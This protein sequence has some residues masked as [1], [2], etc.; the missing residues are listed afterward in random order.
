MVRAARTWVVAVMALGL[1]GCDPGVRVLAQNASDREVVI[2]EA[3]TQWLL[4]AHASGTVF[5]QLGPVESFSTKTFEVLDGASC[6]TLGVEVVDFAST[7]AVFMRVGSDGQV[8]L[9]SPPASMD[10][11]QIDPTLRCPGPATGWTLW[12]V[13]STSASYF[14]RATDIHRISEVTAVGP[15]Q[16]GAAFQGYDQTTTVAVLDS[17]C[18]VLD[19]LERVGWGDSTVTIHDGAFQIQPGDGSANRDIHFL[20]S[21]A[22]H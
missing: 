20:P 2:R 12:V 16:A 3:A 21:H 1:V 7:P 6:A 13:N 5:E 22:C 10:D 15:H 14:L 19:R 18:H 4:P 8:E 9:A 11:G 17:A